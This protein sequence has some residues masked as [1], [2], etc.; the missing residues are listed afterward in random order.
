MPRSESQLP[1]LHRKTALQTSS[2]A[3]PRKVLVCGDAS[4]AEMHAAVEVI[5]REPSVTAFAESESTGESPGLVVLCQSR[6]GSVME[7]TARR[8]LAAHPD[9]RFIHMLG[10]W[11]EGE[12]RTGGTHEGYERVFWHAFPRWWR[13]WLTPV[14]DEADEEPEG[15]A[16]GGGTVLVV[17]ADYETASA[18]SDALSDS[19]F[20]AVWAPRGAE[21]SGPRLLAEK[22]AA[23]IWVGRQLGGVEALRLSR[24]C[25]RMRGAVAPVLAMIDF[26]RAET[27]AHAHAIGVAEV[28]GKPFSLDLLA[29]ALAEHSRRARESTP[30]GGDVRLAGAQAQGLRR[31]A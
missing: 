3:A 7:A 6:P 24:L 31:A 9:A 15:V 17:T 27:V 22:P 28:F 14:N 20:R 30:L 1:K 18:I 4:G 13:S 23:A 25:S 5:G 11:H 26:P 21:H 16:L 10:V 29:E 2:V 19:N 12:E 8:L